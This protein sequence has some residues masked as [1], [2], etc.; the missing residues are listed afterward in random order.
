[1]RR[2][3]VAG[4]VLVPDLEVGLGHAGVGG[5]DEQHRVRVGQQVQRELGL[6]A[7]RVQARRVEDHE[8]LLQQRMREVDDRVAPARNVDA[9]P[10]RR[11]RAPRGCRP[12]RRRRARTCARASTGTR[13]T[14]DT[15]R[16]RLAHLLGVD[17]VERERHPLVGVVLELGDRRVLE[18]RLDRQQPDRRRARRVVEELGR[19]HRRAA[20]RRRQ[21]PLAEVGEEDRVDELGLAARELGDERDDELVLVQALEQLLDLEVDLRVGEVLLLQPLVQA[22]DARRQPAAPV[23]VGLE[24][25]REIARWAMALVTRCQVV[26]AARA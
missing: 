20:R 26:A 17:E 19:A 11:A 5:E 8:A 10:R 2:R 22:G 9:C 21:Q 25:G 14:C 12:R 1:M 15:R 7:D 24:S 23:A 4:E 6:G 16:Q 18:P 13:F 3:I